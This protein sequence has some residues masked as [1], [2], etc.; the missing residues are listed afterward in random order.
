VFHETQFLNFTWWVATWF[1]FCPCMRRFGCQTN[2]ILRRF[3]ISGLAR[4]TVFLWIRIRGATSAK[5]HERKLQ[6]AT[7][8]TPFD[9]AKF[10]Q[11]IIPEEGSPAAIV[12]LG[13]ARHERARAREAAVW[14][15][16]RTFHANRPSFPHRKHGQINQPQIYTRTAAQTLCQNPGKGTWEIDKQHVFIWSLIRNRG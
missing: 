2:S 5:S 4:C 16:G 14:K 3:Q 1:L 10:L 9:A 8:K 12:N 11:S 6:I 15:K 7:V 13:V